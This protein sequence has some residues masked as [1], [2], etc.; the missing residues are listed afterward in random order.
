MMGY[1]IVKFPI[2][3]DFNAITGL[4]FLIKKYFGYQTNWYY[5]AE[6]TGC[7][8]ELENYTLTNGF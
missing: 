1:F 8:D 4:P 3:N 5:T 6:Q 7:Q 2:F